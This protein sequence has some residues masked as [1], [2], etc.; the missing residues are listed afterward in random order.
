MPSRPRNSR[1]NSS[2]SPPSHGKG[3]DAPASGGWLPATDL[4]DVQRRLRAALPD[5][6]A[7]YSVTGLSV[8][9]SFARGEQTAK[10]DVDLLVEFEQVPGW[11]FVALADELEALLG[12]KVD[13][14]RAKYVKPA[15]RDSVLRDATPV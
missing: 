15:I 8:F 12:R 10:S 3:A 7:R 5:L 9:G 14:G 2:I 1:L 11:E 4:A 6:Y 13:L